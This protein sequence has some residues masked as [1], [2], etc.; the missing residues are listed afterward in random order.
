VKTRNILIAV[1]ALAVA[2]AVGFGA[3]AMGGKPPLPANGST[4]TPASGG[5]PAALTAQAVAD[6]SKQLGIPEANIKVASSEAVEWSDGSL[7]CP[8][9][10]MSYA[11]VITP[12]YRIVLQVSDKLYEYHTGEGAAAQVRHCGDSA[13][14]S[15]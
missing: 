3:L 15:K 4:P 14:G 13:S 7:G 2:L 12:G 5:A 8:E 1:A 9:P 6:L 11:Q 10:G